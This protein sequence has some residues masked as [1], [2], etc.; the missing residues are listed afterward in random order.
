MGGVRFINKGTIMHNPKLKT[1]V[2][3]EREGGG[4]AGRALRAV[5]DRGGHPQVADPV[6]K[7][8]G[9]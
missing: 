1:K 8:I 4:K 5:L 3:R 7:M 9:M 6:G 2:D